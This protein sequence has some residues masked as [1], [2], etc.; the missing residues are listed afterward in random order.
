[1]S[2]WGFFLCVLGTTLTSLQIILKADFSYVMSFFF[3]VKRGGGQEIHQ[4]HG[5]IDLLKTKPNW[6]NSTEHL[7]L[8]ESS[9]NRLLIKAILTI[10]ASSLKKIL[11]KTKKKNLS[12]IITKVHITDFPLL[13]KP[14]LMVE[15][16]ISYSIFWNLLC[17]LYYY[18]SPIQW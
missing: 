6:N 4:W 11:P 7:Y 18:S 13:F 2:T 8:L 9:R 5:V 3:L 1:M 10:L 15:S 12:N 17:K 14:Y 16:S